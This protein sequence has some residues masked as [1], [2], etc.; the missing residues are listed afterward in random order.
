MGQLYNGTI[1]CFTNDELLRISGL[2]TME[3]LTKIA[4]CKEPYQLQMNQT[5]FQ[6][7][8]ELRSNAVLL[9]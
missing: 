9:L 8:D 4:C 6:N 2:K 3:V 1:D 5:K 7:I